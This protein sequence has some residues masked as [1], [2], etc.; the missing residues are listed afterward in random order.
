MKNIY[1]C[2]FMGSGKSAIGRLISK[3][4][5]LKHID[6]DREIEKLKGMKIPE[7]FKNYGENYFRDLETDFLKSLKDSENLVIS[8]GGGMMISKENAKIAK[9]NGIIVLLEI[10]FDLCWERIKNS[11]RPLVVNNKKDQIKAIYDERQKIYRLNANIAVS[12]D[13]SSSLCANKI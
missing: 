11:S 2:G 6:S 8:T 4:H 3:R 13:T 10:P 12:N 9:S 1:L 5:G 7:I